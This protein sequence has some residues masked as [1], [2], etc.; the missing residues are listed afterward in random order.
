MPGSPCVP[1]SR[2]RTSR[3][4]TGIIPPST[5]M[6]CPVTHVDSGPTRKRAIA[7][8]SSTVPTRAIGMQAR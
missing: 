3:L 4:V 5:L 7:A 2:L 8:M 6:T 1:A